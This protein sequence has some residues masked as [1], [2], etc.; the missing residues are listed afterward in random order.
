MATRGEKRGAGAR[1]GRAKGLAVK[2]QASSPAVSPRLIECS[3]ARRQVLCRRAR[4]TA[5]VSL[6]HVMPT[7]DGS[8]LV[9]GQRERMQRRQGLAA[10]SLGAEWMCLSIIVHNCLPKQTRV[11]SN[12]EGL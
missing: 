7:R 3:T 2:K 5:C 10:G 12:L 6:S 9:R 1:Q 4:R 8:G 11:L